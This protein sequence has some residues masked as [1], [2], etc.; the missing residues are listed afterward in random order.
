MLTPAD[1]KEKLLKLI[2]ELKLALSPAQAKALVEDLSEEDL[3]AILGE[4]EAVKK[5][6]DEND[7]LL[8]QLDPEKY[9]TL[10]RK[11]K[12][13]LLQLDKDFPSK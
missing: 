6:Q 13:K 10:W 2:E 5:Y 8:G 4:Y 11:Y 12:L 1:K 7:E 9:D 3:D